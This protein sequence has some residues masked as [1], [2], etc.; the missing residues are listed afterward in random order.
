MADKMIRVLVVEDSPTSRQLLVNYLDKEADIE[1]IGMAE[2]GLEA[3]L[4]V[5]QLRPDIIVMDVNMPKMNGFQATKEIMEENPTPIL[6]VSSEWNLEDMKAALKSM[7]IGALA[8]LEKPRGIGDPNFRANFEDL[9]LHV[10]LLSQVKVI[11]RLKQKEFKKELKQIESLPIAHRKFKIIV[12]GASTGG[13]PVLKEILGELP[14]DY[15]LPILVVQHMSYGFMDQFVEWLGT[16]C[17]LRIKKGVEG[18]LVLPGTVYFA[19]E[20]Y[21]MTINQGRIK[22][23]EPLKGELFVPSVSRLFS[24]VAKYDAKETVAIILTGMGRDGAFELKELKDR[25]ALTIVQNEESSVVFG[26]PK[27]AIALDGVTR[28][29]SPLA[30]KEMLLKLV[31]PK[32]KR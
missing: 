26:M 24:S 8:A 29:L 7:G 32:D 2:D 15:P 19:S 18:E 17:K 6:L 4:K 21:D 30:I 10:R 25:G 5:A 27:E 23:Y 1:V 12:I 13:P 28:V 11:R 31:D 22:L 16:M 9:L 20:G 3:T 14:A